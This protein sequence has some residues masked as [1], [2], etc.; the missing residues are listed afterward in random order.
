[1][2]KKFI[3]LPV[4]A[5]LMVCGF[6]ACSQDD[7][8]FEYDLG[9]DEV[10]T[11]AKRSMPRNGEVVIIPPESQDPSR[12]YRGA[13]VIFD[14][15]EYTATSEDDIRYDGLGQTVVYSFILEGGVPKDVQLEYYYPIKEDF[16]VENISLGNGAFPGHYILTS[17]GLD[18]LNGV[19]YIG[20]ADVII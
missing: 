3:I 4:V 17:K 1:M 20:T 10:A 9:N 8:L 18:N 5:M 16:S 13:E 2:K 7:D 6:S 12:T 19:E 14:V 15:L 11:L